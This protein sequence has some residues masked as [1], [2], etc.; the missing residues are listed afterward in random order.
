MYLVELAA[1]AWDLA[2][3]T[4]QVGRLGPALAGPALQAAKAIVKPGY[5]N[6]DGEG[7]PFGPEVEPPAGATLWE[8]FAAFMGRQ[9]R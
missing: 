5:R 2:F 6:A 7:S 4:G 9:P 1:H 8:R 3:A